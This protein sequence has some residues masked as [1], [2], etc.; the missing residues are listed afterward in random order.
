MTPSSVVCPQ[1]LPVSK[2][3]KQEQQSS[4]KNRRLSCSSFHFFSFLLFFSLFLSFIIFSLPLHFPPSLLRSSSFVL[5]SSSH[6]LLCYTH[7]LHQSTLSW[8]ILSFFYPDPSVHTLE[9]PYPAYSPPLLTFSSTLLSLYPL[10]SDSRILF[11]SAPFTPFS[12]FRPCLSIR[13]YPCVFVCF[14]GGPSSIHF[15]FLFLLTC[16][17]ILPS[18]DNTFFQLRSS[19]TL[20]N[21]I[22]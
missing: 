16:R 4:S 10:R 6:S 7:S 21:R 15:L 1:H 20:Y 2:I 12:P 19:V 11:P 22:E 3:A 14:S 17:T 13:R 18:I 5:H 8:S 9:L